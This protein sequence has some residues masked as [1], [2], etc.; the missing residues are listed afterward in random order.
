MQTFIGIATDHESGNAADPD[1]DRDP[2]QQ[3]AAVAWFGWRVWLAHTCKTRISAGGYFLVDSF[4]ERCHH[5]VAVLRTQL[6]VRPG[7]GAE[8]QGGQR[9]VSQS[10]SVTS[11]AW[12]GQNQ[13]VGRAYGSG[14]R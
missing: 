12:D 8:F 4:K 10:D 14:G 6:I 1:A 2:L 5:R 7:G 13:T 3:R 11:A 9:G